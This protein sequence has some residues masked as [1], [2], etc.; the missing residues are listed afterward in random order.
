VGILCRGGFAVSSATTADGTSVRHPRVRAVVVSWNGAHLLPNCLDSLLAQTVA[1]DVEIVV[2]D[3]A[4]EDGTAAM[5]AERYPQVIVIASEKNLGFAGGADL[6]IAG[7]NGSFTALLNNDATFDTD[8]IERMISVM[9]QPGNARVGAVTAKILLA[10]SYKLEH[11]FKEATAPTGSFRRDDGWL[12]P[13]EPDSPG[14]IRVVNS[15]GN[16][17]SRRGTG[18]DRDWLRTEG[19]ESRDA[20]VFGFCGGAALI[21]KT[22]LDKVGGLDR[23][24]FLYYED[25]DLSWRLR[26]GGWTVRYCEKAVAHH[27]H[28]AS[29]DSASPLFRYYN[30]R[31]SLVVF[32]RHAPAAVAAGSFVRQ[33]VGWALSG[34]RRSEPPSVTSARIRGITAFIVGLPRTLKERQSWRTAAVSR[35]KVARLLT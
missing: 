11:G 19:E 25:T 1:A 10:G 23:E 30:T 24:L 4:S 31:N 26:A 22:A 2:V 5:L 17:V 3:N 28:A 18:T 33:L 27:L 14:A 34:V 16:V 6:G 20:D 9:E 8:A 7:F 29:S 21:R 35:A 13:A 15:T 12:V 32:A